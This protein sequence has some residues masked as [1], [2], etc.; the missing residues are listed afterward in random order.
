MQIISCPIRRRHYLNNFVDTVNQIIKEHETL[1]RQKY[2]IN[3]RGPAGHGQPGVPPDN[4]E[5][6]NGPIHC[7]APGHYATDPYAKHTVYSALYPPPGGFAVLHQAKIP[8]YLP[9]TNRHRKES[10]GYYPH[11]ELLP[12]LPSGQR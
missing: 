4:P 3:D 7:D 9:V 1:H 6:D 11:K 12:L 5:K 2:G 8:D 10:S